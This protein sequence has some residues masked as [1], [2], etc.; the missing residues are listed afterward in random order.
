MREVLDG[1]KRPGTH[2]RT[3]APKWAQ[4]ERPLF[5]RVGVPGG[6]DAEVWALSPSDG[7][8]A[9]SFHEIADVLPQ[10]GQGQRRAVTLTP[11][12]ASVVLWI[13]DADGNA[14]CV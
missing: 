12:R 14:R 10:H 1:R 5:V 4:A 11:N 8:R 2:A 6:F 7:A 13:D 3:V 9:L